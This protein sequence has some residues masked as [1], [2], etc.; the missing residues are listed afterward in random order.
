MYVIGGGVSGG[1]DA[2]APTM[3]REIQ[4]RSFVF[5]ATNPK[6]HEFECRCTP[7]DDRGAP[8]F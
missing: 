7:E 1:W 6:A 3:M 2:F 4:A 8:P 5:K